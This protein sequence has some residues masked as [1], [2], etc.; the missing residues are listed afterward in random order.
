[1]NIYYESLIIIDNNAGGFTIPKLFNL[2]HPNTNLVSPYIIWWNEYLYIYFICIYIFYIL[3]LFI[4]NK[5][6]MVE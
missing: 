1:M 4:S 3:Y 5:R 6:Y 2:T